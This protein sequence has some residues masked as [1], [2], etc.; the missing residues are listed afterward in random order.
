MQLARLQVHRDLQRTTGIESSAGTAA[1]TI[2]EQPRRGAERAV[3]SDE[4]QCD[5]R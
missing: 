3:A 1:E 4:I 2:A 5:R